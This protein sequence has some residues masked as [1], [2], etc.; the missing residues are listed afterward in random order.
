MTVPVW[1][2]LELT[3]KFYEGM[4]RASK[5]FYRHGYDLILYVAG[6]EEEHRKMAASFGAKYIHFQNKPVSNK[7]QALMEFSMKDEWDYW[8]AMGSDDFFTENGVDLAV[9]QLKSGSD[10]GMPTSMYIFS[11]YNRNKGFE[12]KECGRIGAGRWYKREVLDKVKDGV[13]YPPDLN[14]ILDYNSEKLIYES[15]G[16]IP[17]SFDYGSYLAD[18]KTNENINSFRNVCRFRRLE[19]HFALSLFDY[20]PEFKDRSIKRLKVK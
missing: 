7:M 18:V 4:K 20:I 9:K 13:I 3:E 5:D 2:R 8:M 1:G 11:I 16:V 6:S 12:F 14:R 10:A 19:N 15:T 17:I